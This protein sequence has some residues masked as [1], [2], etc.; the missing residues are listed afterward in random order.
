MKNKELLFALTMIAAASPGSATQVE[1]ALIAAA[2]AAGPAAKYCLKI[3]ITGSRVEEVKCWTRAKWAAEEVD[4]DE[5]WAEEGVAII[6]EAGR[7]IVKS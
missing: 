3:E 1:P 6:D 2:P 5:E 7:R 4:V